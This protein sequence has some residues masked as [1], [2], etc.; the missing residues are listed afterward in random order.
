MAAQLAV[1]NAELLDL[2]QL[3][4]ISDQL[5]DDLRFVDKPFHIEEVKNGQAMHLCVLICYLK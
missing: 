1:L 2:A 3:L 5:R 4:K